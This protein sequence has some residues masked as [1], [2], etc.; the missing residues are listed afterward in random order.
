MNS[1]ADAD[2]NFINLI[3]ETGTQYNK[4]FNKLLSVG[5]SE[6]GEISYTKMVVHRV[7]TFMRTQIVF[8]R[9]LNSGPNKD[10]ND[11]GTAAPASYFFS[12]TVV[13]F[14]KHFIKANDLKAEA[15][16]EVALAQKKGAIRPDISVWCG[17]TCI[18]T[19]ECKTQLG[20]QREKWKLQHEVRTRKLKEL[21]PSAES[22]LLV[23]TERNGPKEFSSTAGFGTIHFSLLNRQ[24]WP[25]DCDPYKLKFADQ[26]S[27]N[28]EVLFDRIKTLIEKMTP[29]GL[30]IL[31]E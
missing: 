23:L 25:L 15:Y 28:I 19:I 7:A 9:F 21:F 2:Q 20:Y 31:V 22:F 29:D 26:I 5:K 14:L 24:T 27:C 16:Y 12:Q 30:I 1:P 13:F 10:F 3:E 18:A 11:K 8:K 6:F 17:K 4:S